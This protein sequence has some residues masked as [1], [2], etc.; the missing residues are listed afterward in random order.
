MFILY[1]VLD[2][3][4]TIGIG[5]ALEYPEKYHNLEV[6]PISLF[7]TSRVLQKK[8]HVVFLKVKFV[9]SVSC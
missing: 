2:L 6:S 9:N 7:L 1:H 8:S 5:H 3:E 4:S